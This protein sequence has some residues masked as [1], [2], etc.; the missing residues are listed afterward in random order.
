MIARSHAGN[1]LRRQFLTSRPI[2][3]Q[4]RFNTTQSKKEADTS[5]VKSPR[6]IETSLN[7]STGSFSSAEPAAQSAPN[8]IPGP[9]F[10]WVDSLSA[11]LRAYTRAHKKHPYLVQ[12]GTTLIIYL[13]GDISAQRINRTSPEDKHDPMRT[14]RSLI[15][16]G[17]AA[18]P[19]YRWFLFLG[20][21]FNYPSKIL[22]I[23]IKVVINQIIFTPIFNS[24]FF[25]MQ[26]ALAGGSL[27]DIAIRI[28]DTVP[29]SWVNS[30][31]LWPAVIAFNFA[32]VPLHFRS[33]F[34]G[35]IAIGWQ[36]Y[37][38]F[39]NQKAAAK[40]KLQ[41]ALSQ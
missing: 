28:R 6:S 20:N 12:F 41:Q 35:V 15:I 8:T 25:G 9:A 10:F 5:T 24:Y 27:S 38:S 32:F 22:S 18:V 36:T 33:I 31:K 11:P 19:G 40:E 37:L 29:T 13:V 34:A 21:I 7:G 17:L 39:L 30:L 3:R 26:S 1:V 14:V 16:G 23:A 4:R 2:F